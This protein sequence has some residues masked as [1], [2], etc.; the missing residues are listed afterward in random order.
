VG[1]NQ[2]LAGFP[3]MSHV[4]WLRQQSK[5]RKIGELMKTVKALQKEIGELKKEK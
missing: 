4:E 1:D 5:L 3:Q 2:I